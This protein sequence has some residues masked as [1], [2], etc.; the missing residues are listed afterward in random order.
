MEPNP[1]ESPQRPSEPIERS[2]AAKRSDWHDAAPGCGVVI[3][4]LVSPC[5]ASLLTPL[6]VFQWPATLLCV[7]LG[8][9]IIWAMCR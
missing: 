7:A 9:F 8:A 5:I 3:L 2:S 1:Y 4:M 6:G